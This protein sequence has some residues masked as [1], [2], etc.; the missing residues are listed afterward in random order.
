MSVSAWF[1]IFIRKPSKT[2]FTFG[3]N[4]RDG[5]SGVGIVKGDVGK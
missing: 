5:E 2:G 4:A 1:S 3:Q